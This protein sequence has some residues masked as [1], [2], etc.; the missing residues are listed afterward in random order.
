MSVTSPKSEIHH[1]NSELRGCPLRCVWRVKHDEEPVGSYPNEYAVGH[2]IR[3]PFVNP[4]P[5]IPPTDTQHR[6]IFRSLPASPGRAKCIQFHSHQFPAT[7]HNKPR[8][9]LQF[10]A[11]ARSN[12]LQCDTAADDKTAFQ[13]SSCRTSNRDQTQ[14]A[15]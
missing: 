12:I 9:R 8:Y 10:P 13:T 4:F 2:E 3:C 5:K 1:G 11:D 6:A 7:T 14:I 15:G